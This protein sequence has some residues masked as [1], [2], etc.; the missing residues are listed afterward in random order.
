MR[1]YLAEHLRRGEIPLWNPLTYMGTPFLANLQSGVL[2]PP[3]VLLLLPSPIGS[4]LFLFAHYVIALTGMW[5]WLRGHCL[6]PASS[7]VGSLVFTLSGYLVSTMSV[8]PL[9]QGAAWAPWVLH[10][11]ERLG[12]ER[13]PRRGLAFV[14]ALCLQILAGSPENFLLT[15]V[16]LGVLELRRSCARQAPSDATKSSACRLA[17]ARGRPQRSPASAHD[18]VRSLLGQKRWASVHRGRHLVSAAR[19]AAAADLPPFVDLLAS[20]ASSGSVPPSRRASGLL[21]SIYLGVVSLVLAVVGLTR[22][23][24]RALW[25]TV[26]AGG[27]I[28]ALG[29]HTPRL[30]PALRSSYRSCSAGSAIRRSSSSS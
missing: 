24:D 5:M 12:E 9:L 29:N 21:Q 7:A 6:S 2:Y 16:L 25:G 11:W 3:S 30:Q 17:R 4:D 1:H 23:R 22:G 26:A 15:L 10:A 28:L 14:L 13:T 27:L 19:V 18:R 8:T 20:T